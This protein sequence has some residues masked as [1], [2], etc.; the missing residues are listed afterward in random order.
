MEPRDGGEDVLGVGGMRMCR[1]PC[2][3]GGAGVLGVGSVRTGGADEPAGGDECAGLR[4]DCDA[5]AFNLG[6]G[7]SPFCVWVL[8]TRATG[9]AAP[10]RG[11]L[12]PS[13]GRSDCALCTAKRFRAA[14]RPWA[15]QAVCFRF[16]EFTSWPFPL[17]RAGLRGLQTPCV[18]SADLGSSLERVGLL[19][20]GWLLSLPW[21]CS[22]L[23]SPGG[24][25]QGLNRRHLAPSST[26]GILTKTTS[27]KQDRPTRTHTHTL[28]VRVL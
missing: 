9:T 11:C 1:V 22:V 17:D 23:T 24:Q 25:H 21:T 27:K 18:L 8:R 15:H 12:W 5:S 6:L 28:G 13:G 20:G 26:A 16:R 2:G 7:F 3:T 10:G 14:E 4:R 19:G